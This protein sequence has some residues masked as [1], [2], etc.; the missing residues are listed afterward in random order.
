MSDELVGTSFN[1]LKTLQHFKDSF[2][3]RESATCLLSAEEHLIAGAEMPP[4]GFQLARKDASSFPFPLRL[5][6]KVLGFI[7]QHQND[8]SAHHEP[9]F[10]TP[11]LTAEVIL[12]KP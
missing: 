8:S 9:D 10:L 7:H 3:P 2:W 5:K 6:G 4:M 1:V 11:C 12:G